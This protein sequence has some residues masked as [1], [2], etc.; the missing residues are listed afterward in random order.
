MR[1]EIDLPEEQIRNL[2]IFC[3]QENISY[4]DAV[5]RA[6]DILLSR[7]NIKDFKSQNDRFFGLWKNHQDIADAVDYQNTLRAEWDK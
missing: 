3:E 5:K 7:T 2:A 1:T 4:H 6:I